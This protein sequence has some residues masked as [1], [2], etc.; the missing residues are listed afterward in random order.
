MWAHLHSCLCVSFPTMKL[1]Q[2]LL[3]L[4]PSLLVCFFFFPVFNFFH[5]FQVLQ[6]SYDWLD[7]RHTK[8]LGKN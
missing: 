3:F 2:P 4:H 7:N 6:I 1:A 8:Q 5:F